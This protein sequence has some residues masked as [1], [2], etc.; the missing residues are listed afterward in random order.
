M[1]LY[2]YFLRTCILVLLWLLPCYSEDDNDRHTVRIIIPKDN[3][4]ASCRY[5]LCSYEVGLDDD[6]LVVPDTV[7]SDNNNYYLDFSFS[8]KKFYYVDWRKN[9]IPMTIQFPYSTESYTILD[10]TF[11]IRDVHSTFHF[12]TKHHCST[13]VRRDLT[14][15][16]DSNDIKNIRRRK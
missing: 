8:H 9:D 11:Y 10:T 14:I 13:C 4:A 6:N 3:P 1:N 5:P 2:N 16:L 12:T 7:Y 15:I